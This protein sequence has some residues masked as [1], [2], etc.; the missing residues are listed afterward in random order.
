[1]SGTWDTVFTVLGVMAVTYVAAVWL[2]FVVWTY[3]DVRQ[4]TADETERLAATLLVALFSAPGWL[5][6]LLLRPAETLG[7]VRVEQLQAQLFSRELASEASCTRCRRHVDED[8]LMCPYCR[9]PLRVPCAGCDRPIAP[10]WTA[11][12]YCGQSAM[13][14]QA[15]STPARARGDQPYPRPRP[16]SPL[17]AREAR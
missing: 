11:C 4:R 14:P 16:L 5:V 6:Y 15:A 1:M 7:D 8:F 17:V 12:A 3:R 10:T 2:G 9:E 13:R